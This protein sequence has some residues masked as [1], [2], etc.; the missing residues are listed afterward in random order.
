LQYTSERQQF[1]EPL[2]AH[3]LIQAMIADN[4]TQI[5]AARLM[6]YNAAFLKQQ[7]DPAVIMETS[8]A[9]YFASRTAVKAAND[10]VQMHGANG[11]SDAY[12]VARYLRDA[13]IME[14]IEGSNQMQQLLI[15][16][17]GYE[18]LN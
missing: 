6:C 3:Q 15:A 14:I 4:I 12:P 1:G 18:Q 11:C 2:K 17:Y 7:R 9:K 8:M 5:K 13:K 10:A 16:R